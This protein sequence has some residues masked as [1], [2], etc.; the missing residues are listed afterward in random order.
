MFLLFAMLLFQFPVLSHSGF[1][2]M[3][4]VDA[5]AAGGV[6]VA[7]ESASDST[8]IDAAP[9]PDAAADQPLNLG[10]IETATAFMPGRLVPEPVALVANPQPVSG[11]V[12][13]PGA[14]SPVAPF[15]SSRAKII[16]EM[17]SRRVWL[18]LSIASHG[19]AAFDAWTTRRV[20]SQGY[21]YEANPLLR[22]FAGNASLYAAIQVSPAVI[23]YLSHRMMT[24]RHGW[25]RHT[26]WIPQVVSTAVSVTSGMH[27]LGVYSAH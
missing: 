23:D 2:V 26:W 5:P 11:F 3:S 4:A 19:T 22:P 21:G 25:M 24:S 20:L 6:T 15:H 17:G 8:A 14:G 7:P 27:N 18:G 16:P 10:G 9:E 1:A 12:A 13:T